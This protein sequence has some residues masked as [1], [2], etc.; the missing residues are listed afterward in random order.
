MPVCYCALRSSPLVSALAFL[1]W[2]VLITF[3]EEVC[4]CNSIFIL[5]GIECTLGYLHLDVR[6]STFNALAPGM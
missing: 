6:I 2:E 4:M 3:G 1:V 5:I